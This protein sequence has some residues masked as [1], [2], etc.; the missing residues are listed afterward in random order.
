MGEIKKYKVSRLAYKFNRLSFICPFCTF[1]PLQG[2]SGLTHPHIPSGTRFS[3]LLPSPASWVDSGT[4]QNSAAAAKFLP[5]NGCVHLLYLCGHHTE[6][7]G[8][9]VSLTSLARVCFRIIDLSSAYN[10]TGGVDL[11]GLHEN[12]DTINHSFTF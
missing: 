6:G 10:G 1:C 8:C 2:A 9:R 5:R 7:L 3:L 4:L 11:G 12:Q